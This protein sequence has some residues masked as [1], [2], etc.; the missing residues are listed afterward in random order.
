MARVDGSQPPR[1]RLRQAIDGRRPNTGGDR[2]RNPSASGQDGRTVRRGRSR[3]ASAASSRRPRVLA[4]PGGRRGAAPASRS[5]V[6]GGPARDVGAR[7]RAVEGGA[8]PSRPSRWEGRAWV[9]DAGRGLFQVFSRPRPRLPWTQPRPQHRPPWTQPRP[10]PRP[11]WTRPRPPPRPS[12]RK[13][14][15]RPRLTWAQPR[16]LESRGAS[17]PGFCFFC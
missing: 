5:R 9:E 17:S 14:Q 7:P 3:D 8:S 15:P 11:P 10:P 16:P 12:W 13:P 1:R 6:R 2:V 4:S